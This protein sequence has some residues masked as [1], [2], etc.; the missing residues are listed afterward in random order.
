MAKDTYIPALGQHWLTPLYDPLLRWGMRE[1]RFKNSLLAQARIHPEQ[2]VL[3]LGCG[4]GT[5][6]VLIKQ[7]HPD[8]EVIGLDADPQVLTIAAAKAAQAGMDIQFDEGMAYQLP[9]P[10]DS[11]DRVLSSLMFH[12][13]TNEHKQRTLSEVFRVL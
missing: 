11:F 2:R 8:A 3:D 7:A 6:T 9:Y 5:L 4:T 10:D 12:H 1:T 13:L